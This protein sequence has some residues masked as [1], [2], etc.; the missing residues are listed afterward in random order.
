LLLLH[1][2]STAFAHEGDLFIGRS[3]AGQLKV[4]FDT[5]I[6]IG[7]P[8]ASGLL[9]GWAADDPGFASLDVD[10]P[11]EDFYMLDGSADIVLEVVSA[12]PAMKGWTPGFATALD[13]PGDQWA[14]G[15]APFDT[16]LTWHID[17]DDPAF[18][19]LQSFWS[20]SFKVLDV[21]TTEYA[22]S[23]PVV[24]QFERVPEPTSFAMLLV[25]GSALALRRR[26]EVTPR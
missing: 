1:S 19:D 17:Q 23:D 22:E 2:A 8:P 16:H 26:H 10:E 15:A 20:F 14:I 24:L 3:D 6:A 7:L 18:D 21:G 13:L 9:N 25:A 12:S 11:D 4:E 5:S